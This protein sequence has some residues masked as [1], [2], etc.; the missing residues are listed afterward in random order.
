MRQKGIDFYSYDFLDMHRDALTP[1]HFVFCDPPYLIT[2][3]NYGLTW[4][5]R[6]EFS[7]Y[8]FLDSLDKKNIRFM[9]TNVTHH[10][11]N[12]NNIL[13]QFSRNYRIIELTS[14]YAN[15]SYHTKRE[16]SREIMVVNY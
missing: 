1:D 15:S 3:A 12:V 16:P 14:S 7:L 8:S 13:L 4:D 2:Y 5:A 10:K 11:G 6:Y 9:L